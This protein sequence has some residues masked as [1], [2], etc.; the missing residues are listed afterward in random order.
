M[1]EGE[2]LWSW[3]NLQKGSENGSFEQ[4]FDVGLCASCCGDD[5]CPW[6]LVSAVVSFGRWLPL[7]KNVFHRHVGRYGL[8]VRLS[9][10]H[11]GLA[12]RLGFWRGERRMCELPEPI[13]PGY[14]GVRPGGPVWALWSWAA[15]G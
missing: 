15:R 10:S 9:E 13:V 12:I 11:I 14:L 5:M 8:G 3:K 7:W 1:E 2:D 6:R 4:S